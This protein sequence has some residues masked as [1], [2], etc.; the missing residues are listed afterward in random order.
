[1]ERLE[2]P[3][4]SLDYSLTRGPGQLAPDQRQLGRGGYCPLVAEN[5]RQEVVMLKAKDRPYRRGG[6]GRKADA[7]AGGRPIRALVKLLAIA[8]AGLLMAVLVGCGGRPEATPSPIEPTPG[9]PTAAVTPSVVPTETPEVM[10]T[11]VAQTRHFQGDPNAPVTMIEFG[12]F[13]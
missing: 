12:D 2:D 6:V 5:L 10:G 9:A 7:T 11:V 8:I 4:A 3:K 1:M 13:Q